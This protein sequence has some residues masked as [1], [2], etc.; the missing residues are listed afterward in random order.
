MTRKYNQKIEKNSLKRKGKP[1]AR[2][3]FS[4]GDELQKRQTRQIWN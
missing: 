3:Y 1:K 4:L 2:N